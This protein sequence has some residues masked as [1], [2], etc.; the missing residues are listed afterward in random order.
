MKRITTII[1]C[2]AMMILGVATAFMNH[3]F[4]SNKI[5]MAQPAPLHIGQPGMPLNPSSSLDTRLS[6]ESSPIK[7]S[8][9]IIDSIRWETKVRWKTRYKD[10]PER[11]AA[12]NMGTHPLAITPDSLKEKP[13]EMCTVVREEKA[14]DIVDT[15]KVSSIQLI[16]D[17][18]VVYSSNDNHSAEGSQ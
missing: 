5:A 3:E 16:V 7:D 4:P 11:T 17:D 1:C 15:S 10:A 8:I 13:I 2:I 9:N 14:T 6:Y 18:K 12:R